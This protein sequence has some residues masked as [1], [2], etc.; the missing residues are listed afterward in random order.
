MLRTVDDT[1]SFI[2][3]VTRWAAARADVDAVVLVGSRARADLPADRWS[4][5]DLVL[6]VTDPERYLADSGWLSALGTP[7]LTF[8]EPTAVGA[9]AERRVLFED[10]QEVDFAVLPSAAAGALSVDEDALGVLR[11]GFQVLVDKRG[12]T[13]TFRDALGAGGAARLPDRKAFAESRTTSGTTR[14]GAQRSS[15]AARPGS[16]GVA[17]TAT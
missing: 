2:G 3:R 15:A 8:V 5:V 9:F 1:A 14:S 17:A 16:R 7:L 13:A 11:R 10:G 12:L 4:D 6:L